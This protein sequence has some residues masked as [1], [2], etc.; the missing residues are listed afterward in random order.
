MLRHFANIFLY[1]LPP[2]RLFLLRRLMLRLVNVRV[3]KDVKFCGRS[4]IYGRGQMIIED[5][6]WISP[7]C[8]FFTHT[9]ASIRIG[10]DCDIGPNVNMIIGS[11][12]IAD[13]ERRAGKEIA[14]SIRIGAGCWIGANVTIIDGVEISDGVIV[15][16]GSL[17]NS[18]LPENVLV[19]GVPAHIK[20]KL[21]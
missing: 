15:A 9:D 3:G 4:W 7:G 18:S 11:H 16:A 10:A 1:F 20:K 12:E 2:S 19:A 17:V 21:K 8:N 13:Y 14:R 6:T 5:R